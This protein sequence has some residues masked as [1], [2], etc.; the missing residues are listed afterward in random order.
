MFAPKKDII[1]AAPLNMLNSTKI[2]KLIGI[3]SFKSSILLDI[4][5]QI[6]LPY[7]LIFL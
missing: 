6:N 1:K 2:P 3:P 7:R 4:S 5:G